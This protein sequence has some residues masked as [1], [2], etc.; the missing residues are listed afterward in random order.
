MGA[1]DLLAEVAAPRVAEYRQVPFFGTCQRLFFVG[2]NSVK[3]WHAWCSPGHKE[4]TCN[5]DTSS[6]RGNAACH[7]QFECLN[8]SVR[9]VLTGMQVDTVCRV[10]PWYVC[11][12]LVLAGG[13]WSRSMKSW[14]R[15]LEMPWMNNSSW[16][17][18][19]NMVH[20]CLHQCWMLCGWR[21]LVVF[22]RLWLY[23]VVLY[24]LGF[25]RG[26]NYD[27]FFDK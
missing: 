27:G 13:A 10:L 11:I 17:K 22:C 1:P 14:T 15:P 26:L 18:R 23:R 3:V 7:I 16:M 6:K 25:L 2:W 20:Q 9:T 5:Y 8:Y 4:K 19:R 24:V 21:S 12:L